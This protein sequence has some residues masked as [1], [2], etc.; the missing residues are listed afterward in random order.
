MTSD[1]CTPPIQWW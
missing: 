1:I